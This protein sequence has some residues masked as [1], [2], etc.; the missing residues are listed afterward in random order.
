[1]NDLPEKM[2]RYDRVDNAME[3]ETDTVRNALLPDWEAPWRILGV[4][5]CAIVATLAWFVAWL[6]CTYE[7]DRAL[8]EDWEDGFQRSALDIPTRALT[9]DNSAELADAFPEEGPPEE[10]LAGSDDGDSVESKE[11][12]IGDIAKMPAATP[13]K[14][15]PPPD[16]MFVFH[17]PGFKY[18]DESGDVT[19]GQLRDL[20]EGDPSEWESTLP[21]LNKLYR[22]LGGRNRESWLDPD[23]LAA[24]TSFHGSTKVTLGDVRIACLNDIYRLVKAMGFNVGPFKSIDDDQIFLG[25]S[26]TDF[27]ILSHYLKVDEAHLA[28]NCEVAS[29]LGIEFPDGALDHECSPPSTQFHRNSLFF[30][31][32]QA[33]HINIFKHEDLYN[34]DV[35]ASGSVL[36]IRQVYK[37]ITRIFNTEAAVKHGFMC[38]WYP[39][40]NRKKIKLLRRIWGDT[41]KIVRMFAQP[42]QLLH[43]YFGARAAFIFAWH[44][45]YCKMLFAMSFPA[46]IASGAMWFSR[47][48]YPAYAESS[49]AVVQI[50]FSV[51]LVIWGQLTYCLWRREETFFIVDWECADFAENAIVRPEFRGDWRASPVDMKTKEKLEPEYTW[52]RRA[53][54]WVVTITFCCLVVTS[55]FAWFV[56]WKGQLNA[57]AALLHAIQ[58]KVFECLYNRIAIWTTGIENH[59]YQ[60]THYNSY[61]WKL[62]IFQFVNYFY[63][64]FHIAIFQVHSPWGCPGGDCLL[65]L[66]KQLI[67]TFFILVLGDVAV[68]II[69]AHMVGRRIH[70]EIDA[71]AKRK[72]QESL[73]K[74]FQ[75]SRDILVEEAASS[76]SYVEA[77]AKCGV[78]G[79][80]EQI[81]SMVKLVVSFAFV[82][83]FGAVAP[84]VVVLCLVVFAVELRL[85]AYATTH[86]LQR[87]FP[88][89]ATGIGGWGAASESVLTVGTL[90]TAFMLAAFGAVFRGA[91]LVTRLAG[92]LLFCVVSYCTSG[93]VLHFVDAP[94][95]GTK[96][97]TQRRRH[98]HSRLA[99]ALQSRSQD[100]SPST[101]PTIGVK[102]AVSHSGMAVHRRH[103]MLQSYI[104]T[105]MDWKTVEH[106]APKVEQSFGLSSFVRRAPLRVKGGV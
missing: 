36:R 68:G 76:L 54:S 50:W 69:N 9:S 98:M 72:Q 51:V 52:L 102:E 88:W 42:V 59:K 12:A 103:P 7:S 56:I 61:L 89:N 33:H 58:I 8:V 18:G 15:D 75:S 31:N 84:I 70:A 94:D 6:R 32:F 40:H 79:E 106:L 73:E 60:A 83:L 100:D 21:S 71:L 35:I 45:L 38:S 85:N 82:L 99:L 104:H 5:G 43:S 25:I 39:V 90:M 20:F 37:E 101:S 66:Q 10:S 1:M 86:S 91:P 16:L 46:V 65:L 2:K 29:K 34:M 11:L 30:E 57:V 47:W 97:L 74:G 93:A 53:F 24:F 81:E 49:L 26:M 4:A 55:V 27:N 96:L 77:Q 78:F 67:T 87:P 22:K 105:E 13:A 28:L 63:G 14:E 3:R 17:C 23:A 62:Y 64:F 92:L 95:A 80:K 19:A 44:G 41:S 48:F